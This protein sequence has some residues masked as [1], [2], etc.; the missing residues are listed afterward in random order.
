MC[1][2]APMLKTNAMRLLD[3]AQVPYEAH[4]YSADPM[5]ADFGQ[6]VA[7]VLGLEPARTFKTLVLTGGAEGHFVCC[8]PVLANL[9]LKKAASA[10]GA[11]RAE[12]LP[13][14][15]LQRLTGYVRG[16]CTP[17]GLK[18][19]LPVIFDA[20]ASQGAVI[21]ISSGT[22]GLMLT[23]AAEPLLAMLGARE[24]DLQAL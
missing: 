8:L 6:R 1:Y 18:R 19:P 17:I 14:K 5:A 4:E 20:T 11:K 24:A 12:L 10:A 15:D 23:V 9:D 2:T 22:C 16:G 13:I 21:G 3:K 7:A